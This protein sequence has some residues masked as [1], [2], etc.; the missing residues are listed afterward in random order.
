MKKTWPGNIRELENTNRG[1]VAVTPGRV[2]TGVPST[3]S[4][5]DYIE[6]EPAAFEKPYKALKEE[7]I[8]FFTREYLCK[9][10]RKTKGKISLS[11]AVSGIERQSLQK[12]IKRY[13][14]Q[15]EQY[16]NQD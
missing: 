4:P 3:G 1:W 6:L 14:V 12:I 16:R 13:D 5:K 8:E 11:A 15:V 10:L 2:I 7:A 9:L